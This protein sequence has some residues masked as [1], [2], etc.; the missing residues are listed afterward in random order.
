[1]PTSGQV[2]DTYWTVQ[3][4]LTSISSLLDM[5]LQCT[6]VQR[7]QQFKA[8]QKVAGYRH[9]GAPIVELATVLDLLVKSWMNM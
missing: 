7:L 3:H 1:M 6:R 8:T 2:R 4:V 9:D 5:I